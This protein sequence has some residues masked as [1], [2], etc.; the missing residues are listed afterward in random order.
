MSTEVFYLKSG[1]EILVEVLKTS[2]IYD[3]CIVIYDETEHTLHWNPQ[4]SYYS[5]IIYGREGFMV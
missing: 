2:H 3:N 5:G 4:Y 1:G